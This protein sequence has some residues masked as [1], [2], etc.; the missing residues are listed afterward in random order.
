[1]ER[2][3]FLVCQYGMEV[4]GG[5]EYH[6]RMLAERLKDDYHVDVLTSKMI[7]YH[8]FEPFYSNNNEMLNG[9][10]II[11]FD[12]E[13]YNDKLFKNFK[14]KTKITRKFRRTLFR[15][16]ILKYVAN[17]F[18]IWSWGLKTEE[19]LAKHHGFYS[20]Q[21]LEYLEKNK[22]KYKAII[23]ISYHNPHAIF[24]S[25]IAPEKTILI[26][27][28][29]NESD[30]FRGIQTKL[31]TSVKHIAFNTEEEENL[32]RNIYGKHMSA[33][34]I[35]AVGIETDFEQTVS[36][37][38]IRQKFNLPPRYIHYFGRIC[39]SKMDKLIP[40]FVNYKKQYPSD[41]KLVLT[42]RI[43]Q[44]KVNLPDIQYTGFVSDEEKIVLIKNATLIINPSKNESLS[45]LLLEA[46]NLGKTVIVN[47]KSDVM[48]GHAL[49]SG[50]A[51]EYYLKEK[52]FQKV[53]NKY[54][55]NPELIEKNKERAKNYVK[56]NYHWPNI[57]NR[58]KIL[59]D[60]M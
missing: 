5:A 46:M 9:V 2:I 4:N 10:N 49:K 57:L 7:N 26:P 56:T 34:S 41:I 8:S 50:F 48:K 52:D 28:I 1:M 20:P 27:T 24:G 31:F 21:M 35:V 43:F 32:S 30:A 3:C 36:E 29:H 11:R 6:C 15:M 55:D 23:P 17:L 12:C 42:G 47:S 58:L 40:W 22:D 37:D 44:K 14:K 19:E 38:S 54:L 59:I 51:T 16:G 18:P 53:L 39:D 33:S 45:L 60:S 25:R 13:P